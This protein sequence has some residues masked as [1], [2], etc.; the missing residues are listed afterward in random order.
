MKRVLLIEPSGGYIRLDR[1]MQSINSWGGAYRFP[2]NLARIGAHLMSLG[3]EVTFL[4]L[5]ADPNANLPDKIKDFD[6]SI[7]IMSC[8]FP[9]MKIDAVTAKSVKDISKDIHVSTF[10]V[11]PTL[12]NET[13]F[14]FET[15]GFELPFDSIVVGGEPALGYE[16]L[17]ESLN[18][19]NKKIVSSTLI[20]VKD[21]ETTIARPMFNHQLYKSPFTGQNATYIEG[22]YGCPFRCNFCVVPVLYE[23]KF[24]KRTP[25]D[26]VNE[27]K[28][29]I[30]NDDVMQITLWDEGTTFQKSFINELCEGLIELRKSKQEKLKNFVWTTRSTTA[31][32]DEE[33]VKKM[34]QSGL[35]GIT[36]GIESFDEGILDNVEK[37]ISV[38]SNYESIRLLKKYGIISIGH[39]I[40]GHLQDTKETIE[41]TIDSAV[42]SD[43][44]F[45]QFYCAVPY[46]GTK[47]YETANSLK[48]I[49]EDDLTK[50]EL[51]NPIMDTLNGV[52][53]FEVGEFR[54][55]A[56]RKFWTVQRWNDLNKL[57][58]QHSGVT[59]ASE[60]KQRILEWN[61]SKSSSQNRTKKKATD[62]IV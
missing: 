29:V 37:K 41:Y 20:K 8:G 42:R 13:F 22:T 46:P 43:L 2:L 15:W 17:L 48:L 9:S 1:C 4:D 23:G 19:G 54:N 27:F 40:L 62:N 11:A 14:N 44:N 57:I 32:L 45:A 39:F 30:E 61:S 21:I 51:S 56:T 60:R 55:K 6:P 52:R 58:S 35:S 59:L 24:S 36:L 53:H 47:L 38:E 25:E 7:C 31:L 34:Y 16:E 3:Y 10:G 28:Y 26:I 33:I 12:L 5:Q 49:Q 18:S 50:Y